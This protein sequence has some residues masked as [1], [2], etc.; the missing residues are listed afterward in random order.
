MCS[1]KMRVV[2][3]NVQDGILVR[4]GTRS[5]ERNARI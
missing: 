2:I 1:S 5:N 4:G 3:K